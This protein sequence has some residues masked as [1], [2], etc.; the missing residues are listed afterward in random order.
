MPR[1]LLPDEDPLDEL[2][3]GQQ[4]RVQTKGDTHLDTPL[5]PPKGW[6]KSIEELLTSK[7]GFGLETATLLQRAICN[8]IQ[9][10]PLTPK[11]AVSK[12]VRRALGGRK[13]LSQWLF[14]KADKQ[15]AASGKKAPRRTSTSY[16]RRLIT[17]IVIVAAI[18]SAKSLLAAVT[19]IWDSQTVRV[20]HLADGEI[21]RFTVFSL[22]LDN[23]RAVIAHL[24]GALGKKK[25]QHLLITKKEIREWDEHDPWRLALEE[26]T[27]DSVVGRFVLR[28]PTGR[29]M[30]IRVVAGKRAGASGLSRWLFGVCADEATRM[31]GATDAVVNYTH[32]RDAVEGRLLPGAHFLTIGSPWQSDGPVYEMFQQ[33]FG[34]KNP[35]RVVLVAAGPDM[36]PYWWTPERCRKLKRKNPQAY[37]TDVLGRFADAEQGLVP[38]AVI[39]ASTRPSPLIIQYEPGHDYRA[40]MDPG[41][42]TNAW[43]L[44]VADCIRVPDIVLP[45][46][47]VSSWKRKKRVVY[48][49]EWRGTSSTPLSPKAVLHES[50]QI[51]AQYHLQWCYTDQFAAD[52]NV[53]LASDVGLDLV[54]D[55]WTAQNKSQCALNLA[56]QMFAG[57]I[58][59]PND[60][61]FK[62]DIRL[63]KKKP[64]QKGVQITLPQTPDG[65]HCDYFPPLMKCMNE[66]IQEEMV[67]PPVPGEKSY[68]N[69]L[70]SL[71][72]EKEAEEVSHARNKKHAG[73]IYP[74]GEDDTALPDE[75]GLWD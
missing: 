54:V 46:G 1:K 41:T 47:E 53:D 7:D 63:V 69:Y 55:E 25:L 65:R 36:N 20:A 38:S 73:I 10:L 22:S 70:D 28:H 56:A 5:D 18:R 62:R 51:L 33:D 14:N 6:F 57:L 50:A 27:D 60:P 9:G 26:G 24:A 40:A 48:Y 75:P 23:A 30:E 17:D 8:I 13:W 19:A 44:V 59:I 64:I 4:T 72:E 39:E 66:W 3:R 35:D 34:R 74:Y 67:P 32:M 37:I 15:R 2:A 49:C 68:L 43:T 58:E 16:A 52:A 61:Q 45:S 21:P 42:R 11:Q 12:P 71:A 29:P 31:Y